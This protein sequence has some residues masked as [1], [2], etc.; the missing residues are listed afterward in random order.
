MKKLIALLVLLAVVF[1]VVER[2]RVYVRDVLANTARD[3]DKVDGEQVYINYYNDVLLENDNPPMLFMSVEHGQPLGVPTKLRCVHW[4]ACLTDADV[5][6]TVPLDGSRI[7]SM[8]GKA[9]RFQDEQHRQWNVSL[10]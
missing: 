7:Q 10:R 4:V 8:N 9:V 1:V 2:K 3:G 5:A 6:S